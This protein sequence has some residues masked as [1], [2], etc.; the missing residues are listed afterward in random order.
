MD[1]APDITGTRSAGM[2]RLPPAAEVTVTA[3][4]ALLLERPP[5]EPA[6]K[7]VAGR[8]RVR[9]QLGRGS[10]GV[11]WLA[12]DE[13]LHRSV[14]LK[15]VIPRGPAAE[16]TR[17]TAPAH[18]LREARAAASIDHA[19]VVRIHD[20]VEDDGL[21]WVVMEL[22][23]GHTLRDT[24]DAEGTLPV[25]E[26]TRV[27]LSLLDAL[28]ATHRAGIVH[29]DVKP[30]NV[31]LCDGGR[32]V[33]TDFGIARATDDESSVPSGEF[34][35]SPAYVAPEQALGG[36]A[37]PASDL[38]SLG[39]TLFAAVE[40]VPPFSRGSIFATLAAVLEDAPG[41]FLRAG[42]LRPVIEGMLAKKPERRLSVDA[43]RA[44]LEAVQSQT[45]APSTPIRSQ[46]RS[47]SPC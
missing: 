10:M 28:Q 1:A 41:P 43:A 25:S 38:F 42:P 24:L 18:A 5:V 3:V 13:V 37:G 44:A 4:D 33:L 26:V 46:S 16:E 39:A 40:G 31:Q 15:Q 22:L 36:E 34:I 8:Y 14:A 17:M 21:A 2:S 7:L 45:G 19:G 27:G 6:M 23:S 32:V 47:C 35:G 29:R 12:Q 9:S 20:L 11:V 30:G